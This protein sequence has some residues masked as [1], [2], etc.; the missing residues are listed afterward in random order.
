M[1]TAS[2][3]GGEA[4]PD[5]SNF[6]LAAAQLRRSCH[7]PTLPTAGVRDAQAG[8]LCCWRSVGLAAR[9]LHVVLWTAAKMGPR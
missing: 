5:V 7:K 2:L 1:R 8:M 4:N 6:S 3:G 9:R